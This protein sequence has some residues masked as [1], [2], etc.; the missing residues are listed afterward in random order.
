MVSVLF[1]PVL[2]GF[3]ALSVDVGYVYSLRAN[4]QNAV[5]LAA[6]GAMVQLRDASVPPSIAE[7][8]RTLKTVAINYA[9]ENLRHNPEG[10]AVTPDD[11]VFGTWDFETQ[12]MST[13]NKYAIA[14]AV[15]VEAHFD[16]KRG[17]EVRT[18]LAKLVYDFFE[19]SIKS[20]SVLSKPPTFHALAEK[21]GMFI[22]DTDIDTHTILVNARSKNA[23]K[24]APPVDVGTF[25]MKRFDVAGDAN[26]SGPITGGKLTTGVKAKADF[27]AEV[28][29]PAVPGL[30]DYT[31]T[32]V[33]KPGEKVVLRPGVYCEG[34]VL[35]DAN[36]VRFM[37]GTY[38]IKGGSFD[39]GPGMRGK[40]IWGNDVLFYYVKN[41]TRR[42]PQRTQPE[43]QLN[44]GKFVFQ[45]KQD[46]AQAGILFFMARGPKAPKLFRAASSILD[47]HGTIYAPDTTVL[48]QTVN[49][50]GRCH[51]MCLVAQHINF[52]KTQID[53]YPDNRDVRK[54]PIGH[55]DVMVSP[56]G[57]SRSFRPYVVERQLSPTS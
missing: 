52:S 10:L 35:E 4:A 44:Y 31:G 51:V 33:S 18:I 49:M 1:M 3:G 9:N 14:D 39:T 48:I 25:G 17:N 11:I 24:F 7:A 13:D 20:T 8:N 30:C 22:E 37:P 6:L 16:A 43:I 46:G 27:F 28:P 2:I 34:I 42:G 15:V 12:T 40:L 26:I 21:G 50:D 56:P 32:K 5:D 47:F 29:E 55:R 45:A 41:G 57:L 19:F 54:V 23:V 38:I 36:E 53:Y